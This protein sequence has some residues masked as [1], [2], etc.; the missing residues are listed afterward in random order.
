MDSSRPN[1]RRRIDPAVK[2][3]NENPDST[4]DKDHSSVD[5]RQVASVVSL[6]TPPKEAAADVHGKTWGDYNVNPTKQTKTVEAAEQ[7]AANDGFVENEMGKEK[8]SLVLFLYGTGHFDSIGDRDERKRSIEEFLLEKNVSRLKSVVFSPSK[9]TALQGNE[10]FDTYYLF[11][12]ACEY[13]FGEENSS[14]GFPGKPYLR[15]QKSSNCYIAASATFISLCLQ[16][17]DATNE[18]IDVGWLARHYVT[19]T[20]DGLKSRIIENRGGSSKNLVKRVLGQA[21]WRKAADPV[22][23]YKPCSAK[24]KKNLEQRKTELI[25]HLNEGRY[26]LVSGWMVSPNFIEITKQEAQN[27]PGIW[28]FDD[29]SFD[30]KGRYVPF[31][32]AG[33]ESKKEEWSADWKNK[34]QTMASEEDENNVTS[35]PDPD[36]PFKGDEDIQESGALESNANAAPPTHAMVLLGYTEKFGE[37]LFI[38]LNW[39]KKMPLIGV[40]FEYILACGCKI[41]FLTKDLPEDVLQDKRTCGLLGA[42]CSHPDYVEDVEEG[43]EIDGELNHLVEEGSSH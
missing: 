14:R 20:L 32:I 29:E 3:G 12:S 30:A 22:R 42:E 15:I 27:K 5:N 40:S 4:P 43:C 26:G 17:Q 16:K 21:F 23:L 37:P 10:G 35:I 39:W 25:R 6:T 38:I 36:I 11:R 31:D 28:C 9:D 19:N 7:Q 41:R 24:E 1:K 8:F 33:D 18:P 13:L 2:S 34:I